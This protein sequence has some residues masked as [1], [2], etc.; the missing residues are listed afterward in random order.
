MCDVPNI[1]FLSENL[2]CPDPFSHIPFLIYK[3]N[4]REIFD[5]FIQ[6]SLQN[7]FPDSPGKVMISKQLR[8][9]GISNWGLPIARQ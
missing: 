3:A 6:S 4:G 8:P 7:P 1:A 9:F 2:A 5:P